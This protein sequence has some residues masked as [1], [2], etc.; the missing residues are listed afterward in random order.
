MKS[1]SNRDESDSSVGYVMDPETSK[2]SVSTWNRKTYQKVQTA[3]STDEEEDVL[4][5]KAPKTPLKNSQ[6][7][8]NE[9]TLQQPS[10]LILKTTTSP[11]PLQSD[12]SSSHIDQSNPHMKPTY[13]NLLRYNRPFR[14]FILCHILTLIGEYVYK[15]RFGY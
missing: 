3:L 8:K 12:T 4:P 15:R 7:F 2:T 1:K 9:S 10:I 13:W 5:T 6:A 11:P 14:L